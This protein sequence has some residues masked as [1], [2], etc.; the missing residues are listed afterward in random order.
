MYAIFLTG[1][2]GAGKSLLTSVL[3]TWYSDKGATTIAVNLDPGA[4]SC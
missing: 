3:K 2:A 4:Y 1:T